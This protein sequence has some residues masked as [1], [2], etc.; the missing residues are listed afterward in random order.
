[1]GKYVPPEKMTEAQIRAE[2]DQEFRRWEQIS[3]EGCSDPGWPDGVNMNLVRNHII[4]WYRL[5]RD[6]LTGDVQ[7]S[8]FEG[9]M[10]LSRE[11]PVP[12]EVPNG[13]M[14]RN[15]KYPERIERLS[16]FHRLTFSLDE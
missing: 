13:Y 7:L 5:L 14:V 4:Y 2:L 16:A 6:K 10:D 3:K 12:P 11:R 1:M 8:L 9:G 15:G